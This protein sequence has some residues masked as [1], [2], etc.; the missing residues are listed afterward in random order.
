MSRIDGLIMNLCPDGVE[1]K[2]L[3]ELGRRNKGTSITAAR[4][5]ELQVPNGPIRVFAGGQ[6]IADVAENSV[7]KKDVVHEPSIVV[8]SRGHIGFTYYDRPF[9]HKTE[10]WSYTI[11]PGCAN[12]KFVY[13]YLLTQIR[14]LQRVAR[15]TSVKLPQ[16][17]VKD[18]DSLRI[19][20]PPLEIQHEIVRVL[21]TFAGLEAQLEAQLEAELEARKRQHQHYH[22][23]LL[24]FK[25]RPA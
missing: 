16:L 1:F 20:V 12:Q 8:K 22:D 17:G 15:A 4:M 14:R 23:R 5:K 19:P 6:T 2:P 13:Y 9:T 11:P 24:T 21:D 7:P 3:G 25:E 18:T 10:L